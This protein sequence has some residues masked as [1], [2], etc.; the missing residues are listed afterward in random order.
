[1][2]PSPDPDDLHAEFVE[3]SRFYEALRSNT[4]F[5]GIVLNVEGAVA[6]DEERIMLFQR[7]NA[8]RWA[9]AEPGLLAASAAIRTTN[10]I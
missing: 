7:G 2:P 10:T 9:R 8:D 4:E 6:I 5:C 1:M 3:A